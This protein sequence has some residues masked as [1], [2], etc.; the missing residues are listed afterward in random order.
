MPRAIALL[1]RANRIAPRDP[2]LV[3]S[4]GWALF[5]GGQA[6]KALPLIQSAVA[7]AP[8][9][10]EIN[11]HLGDIYWALGRRYEARAAWRAA[12]VGLEPDESGAKIRARL[13]RKLDFGTE[14]APPK[15]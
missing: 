3:D 2:A 6:D 10:A 13:T 5:K 7:A 8:G 15:P 12:L 11:E 9:N 4:L 14:A 1:E